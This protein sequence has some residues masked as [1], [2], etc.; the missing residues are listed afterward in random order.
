MPDNNLGVGGR[1]VFMWMPMATHRIGREIGRKTNPT[2]ARTGSV[3]PSCL[4]FTTGA[5]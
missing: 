4:R 2:N 1:A 5:A 3:F